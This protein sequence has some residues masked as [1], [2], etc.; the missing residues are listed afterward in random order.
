[1]DRISKALDMARQAR[2]GAAEWRQAEQE[3]PIA[4]TRTR[5]VS[6]APETLRK[7]RIV[8]PFR[9]EPLADAYRLLRTRILHRM[10]QNN[11]RTL[12]IT[13]P[14]PG[15]GKTL[16]AIN[17]AI[18]MAMELNHTVLLVDA[19]LR[20]PNIHNYF[21]IKPELGLNDYLTSGTSVEEILINPGIERFVILPGREAL[22][23]SSELLASSRMTRLVQDFKMRYQS[24]MVIFDL[25][26]VLAGDDVVAFLPQLDTAL[27]VIED[28][29]SHVDEIK[30][31]A[32][33]LH[34]IELVGTVLNKSKS[35][36]SSAGYG[37]SYS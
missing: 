5:V 2:G 19:D 20:R 30:R 16:T 3:K 25:P 27:L 1:M 11:W 18:G 34:G 37:Y 35:A 36:D 10:K 7:A 29:K 17:L 24:R 32:E 26:P 15:E 9:G 28:G 22:S 4:Y 21:A 8:S 31:T 13:S 12:G 14:G 23:N 33:L 6:V